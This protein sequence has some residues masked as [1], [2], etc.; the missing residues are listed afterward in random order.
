MAKKAVKAKKT[1]AGHLPRRG[2]YALTARWREDVSYSRELHRLPEALRHDEIITKMA[3]ERARRDCADDLERA[4]AQLPVDQQHLEAMLQFE[5]QSADAIAALERI[6]GALQRDQGTVDT[7]INNL[8]VL[9][10]RI[11]PD[12]RT[13]AKQAG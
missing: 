13:M 10:N 8:L 1:P 5:R 11:A 6:A 12:V 4:I 2:L 9:F 7:L 3:M